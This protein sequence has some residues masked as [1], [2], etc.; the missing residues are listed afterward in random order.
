M[1]CVVIAIEGLNYRC[2]VNRI[3]VDFERC[4]GCYLCV[5]SCSR[6]LIEVGGEINAAGYYPVR[7]KGNGECKACVLCARVCPEAAIEVYRETTEK[8]G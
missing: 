2:D 1:F 7:P 4:K 8:E 6:G 3:I 5:E